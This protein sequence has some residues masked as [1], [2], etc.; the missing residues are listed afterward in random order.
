MITITAL[1]G[2]TGR[3]LG[4]TTLQLAPNAH[5]AANIGPLLNL[6]SF[7]GSVQITATAPIVSL[8]LNA[9]AFPVV[10]SLPPAIYPT[11]LCWPPAAKVRMRAGPFLGG[12]I[13]PKPVGSQNRLLWANVSRQDS[14]AWRPGQL[15]IDLLKL[16]GKLTA[17]GVPP[18]PFEPP[19]VPATAAPCCASK[20]GRN[21]GY[22]PSGDRLVRLRHVTS[23]SRIL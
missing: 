21:R 4:S 18:G 9:E 22:D 12:R 19:A 6:N 5:G 20:T 16:F 8:S 1:D 10:S 11:A 23:E 14:I 2:A 13:T 15:V 7:T 17:R 3:S